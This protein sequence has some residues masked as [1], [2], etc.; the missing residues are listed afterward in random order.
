MSEISYVA[1]KKRHSATADNKT[2]TPRLINKRSTGKFSISSQSHLPSIP[3]STTST[4]QN[5]TALL[6]SLFNSFIENL[7]KLVSHN[8][9][10]TTFRNTLSP[11]SQEC[12]RQFGVFLQHVT[13]IFGTMPVL[14]KGKRPAESATTVFNSSLLPFLNTWKNFAKSCCDMQFIG[15]DAI[16]KNIES[17]FD[18]LTLTLESLLQTVNGIKNNNT[19]NTCKIDTKSFAE[20]NKF[21]K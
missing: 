6:K 10:T 8:S 14:Q 20:K 13:K 16:K 15:P 17:N 5:Q 12:Q 21:T 4:E 3:F 7:S 19:Y 9:A 11:Q 2:R 1:Q 18:I